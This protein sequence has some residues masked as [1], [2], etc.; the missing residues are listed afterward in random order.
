MID[1]DLQIRHQNARTNADRKQQA[2]GLRHAA[3]TLRGNLPPLPVARQTVLRVIDRLMVDAR[4]L[5]ETL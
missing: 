3:Q 5:E 4:N 1:V 2:A